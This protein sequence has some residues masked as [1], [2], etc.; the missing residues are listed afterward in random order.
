MGAESGE[1]PRLFVSR[2]AHVEAV[3]WDDTDDA[4]ER[5]WKHTNGKVE[6]RFDPLGER[7]LYLLA[8]KDG[9]QEWVPVPVGHW[10]VHPPGDTSDIWP[11][12]DAY[13]HGK[14]EPAGAD[15]GRFPQESQP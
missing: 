15:S 10:L 6:V 3:L 13:F 8:G 11:V 2:P 5:L 12:E 1:F 4:V 14:Y 7:L 9:A